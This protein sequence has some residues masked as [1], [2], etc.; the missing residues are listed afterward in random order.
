MTRMN[1]EDWFKKLREQF[2]LNFVR[3]N[4]VLVDSWWREYN[5]EW[6]AWEK[7]EWLEYDAGTEE[8]FC[9]FW[10]EMRFP[11]YINNTVD[12]IIGE[13]NFNMEAFMLWETLEGMEEDDTY[14]EIIRYWYHKR[15]AEWLNAPETHQVYW[16]GDTNYPGTCYLP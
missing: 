12:Q 13:V 2:D 15:I 4:K 5:K 10:N 16:W 14:Y 8:G 11:H 6:D 3:T 7:G 1:R 9:N